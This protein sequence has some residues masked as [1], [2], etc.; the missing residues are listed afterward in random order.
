MSAR[1]TRLL[2]FGL[3]GANSRE[4]G[5]LLHKAV[6]RIAASGGRRRWDGNGP[7]H[8]TRVA[9]LS[10][11]NE[12]LR[13]LIQTSRSVA[14]AINSR[15]VTIPIDEGREFGAFDSLPGACADIKE[16]SKRL[17]LA[18]S[19][20]YGRAGRHFVKKLVRAAFTDEA[21]LV[22]KIER[23]TAEFIEALDR[24]ERMN[25]SSERVRQA[26]AITYA[27]GRL[28]RQWKLIPHKWG[29]LKVNLQDVYATVQ[30][31][32]DNKQAG[33]SALKT[34]RDYVRRNKD[35]LIHMETL[36]RPL[37]YK[38]FKQSAGFLLER[39]GRRDVLIPTE[40]F[41]SEFEDHRGLMTELRSVGL[42]KP[43]KEK[44]RSCP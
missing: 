14:A 21:A 4:Q 9:L 1:T 42:A 22:S 38:R 13:S 2:C 29:S 39:E 30:G 25:G 40:R 31:K 28:A 34:I 24:H 23:Y 8:T 5:Q 20:N 33:Q 3:I 10:T 17:R 7:V 44:N 35:D 19:K 12:P 16:A 27:A 36:P 11:S 15:V 6:F 26:F 32:L 37:K 43:R 18:C 41:K